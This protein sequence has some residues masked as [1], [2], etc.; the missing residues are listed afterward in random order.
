MS[1]SIT[2]P[3]REAVTLR[4]NPTIVR[5]FKGLCALRGLKA[6]EVIEKMMDAV[7][8]EARQSKEIV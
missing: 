1:K 7:I 6:N 5:Q 8:Q 3:I 2:T 4:I